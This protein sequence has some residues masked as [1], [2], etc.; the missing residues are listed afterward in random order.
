MKR[1]MDDLEPHNKK[2]KITVDSVPTRTIPMTI[3]QYYKD[4]KPLD[5]EFIC[6][7]GSI[8]ISELALRNS[9]FYND[10]CRGLV[11]KKR[12]R[13]EIMKRFFRNQK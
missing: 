12:N 1:I 4:Q 9:D 13:Y 6:C 11:C 8:H 2:S 3:L 10:M 7:D 5:Y